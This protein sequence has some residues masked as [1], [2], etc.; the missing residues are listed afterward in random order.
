MGSGKRTQAQRTLTCLGRVLWIRLDLP[1]TLF[2]TSKATRWRLESDAA[3]ACPIKTANES[4]E[5][6][7]LG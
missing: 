2:D 7:R 4:D 3:A 1:R 5:A 6:V